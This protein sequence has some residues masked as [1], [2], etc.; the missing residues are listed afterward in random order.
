MKKVFIIGSSDHSKE[1]FRRSLEHGSIEI[2]SIEEFESRQQLSKN[3]F[4][5]E[6]IRLVESLKPKAIQLTFESGREKRRKRR[7]KQKRK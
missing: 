1:V 4:L 3:L 2:L 7:K 6:S 5:E